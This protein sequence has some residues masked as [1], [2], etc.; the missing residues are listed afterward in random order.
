[1]VDLQ[2]AQGVVRH[3]FR[4]DA[5]RLHL[6]E[7]PHPPE[8]PVGDPGRAPA[9]AGDLIGAL[10]HDVHVQDPGA[11]GDDLTEF[12]R[13]IELQPQRHAEPVP[14][15][16]GELPGPGGSPDEGELGQI[17]PDGVG[18][19]A[20]A[21]DDVQGVVLHGGIEDLLHRAVE[22]VNLVHEEDIPLA[23]VGEK[24]CQVAGLFNGRAGGD[25]DVHP[26]LLGDD[27]RQSGLAQARGAVEQ[28]VVQCLLPLPGG[29]DEDRQVLLGLLL[30]DVLP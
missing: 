13:G 18:A 12:L 30:A 9:A 4:D 28:H 16:R 17:Q 1:M 2:G 7:V 21:H 8:H 23:E 27:A 22:P 14:Q 10:R 5:V 6:G 3:L 24:R 25:A 20:L 26:H 29:L 19:G 11:A 15:R